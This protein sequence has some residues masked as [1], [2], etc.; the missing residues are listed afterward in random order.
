M[1]TFFSLLLF[2]ELAWDEGG[3]GEPW[4]VAAVELPWWFLLLRG[5]GKYVGIELMVWCFYDKG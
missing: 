4:L 5:G 1:F 3:L 2:D